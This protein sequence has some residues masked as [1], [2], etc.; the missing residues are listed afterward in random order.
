MRRHKGLAGAGSGLLGLLV[1][2]VPEYM[3]L[4]KAADELENVK[5]QLNTVEMTQMS[6]VT[7]QKAAAERITRQWER[8]GQIDRDVAAMKP[9]VERIR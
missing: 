9:K 1:L 8:I 6:V 2:G 4:R 3:E 5:R 7:E